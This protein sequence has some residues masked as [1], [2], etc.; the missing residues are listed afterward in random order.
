MDQIITYTQAHIITENS[1]SS[2]V[3]A[4]MLSFNR[5]INWKS[6]AN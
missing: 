6:L 1:Y 3:K 4:I 2:L 5:A